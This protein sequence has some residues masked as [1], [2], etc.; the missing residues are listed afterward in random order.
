MPNPY[1]LLPL[2]KIAVL[3]CIDLCLVGLVKNKNKICFQ[4]PMGMVTAE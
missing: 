3:Y 1:H 4:N 2:E